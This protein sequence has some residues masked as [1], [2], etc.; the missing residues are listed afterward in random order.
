[1]RIESIE[2]DLPD[3][4][5]H[6]T[7]TL[8]VLVTMP[9]LAEVYLGDG[10]E[11]G[12][13]GGVHQKCELHAVPAR[14]RQALDELAAHGVFAGEGLG[15]TGKFGPVQVEQG[16]GDQ[17]GDAATAHDATAPIGDEGSVVAGLD[18]VDSGVGQ[19]RPEEP[20]DVIGGEGVQVGVD[21]D[22]DIARAGGEAT[23][24]RLALACHGGDM[25]E[26]V[27]G[28]HDACAGLARNLSGG[29]GAV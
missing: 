11:A 3:L 23:P 5:R 6:E 22:D 7:E 10:V 20:D 2:R 16:T 26:D 9:T 29:I 17:L 28:R 18:Q 14:D 24:H 15:H 21:E 27:S 19:D 8:V 4:R 13:L 12:A 1:V 25:G